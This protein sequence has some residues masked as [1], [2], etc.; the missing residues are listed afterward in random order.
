MRLLQFLGTTNDGL[1]IPDDEF[2]YYFD[3]ALIIDSYFRDTL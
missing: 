3:F 2:Y 1:H